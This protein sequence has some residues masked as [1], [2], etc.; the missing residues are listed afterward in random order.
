[1]DATTQIITTVAGYGGTFTGDNV[2]ATSTELNSPLGVTLDAQGNLYIADSGN[3]RVRR[4]DATTQIIT[5]V[6]GDGTQ[7]YSGDGKAA[8]DAELFIPQGLALDAAGNL[9]IADRDNC[10][11]YTSRCV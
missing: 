9:Y 5:T 2:P 10:L 1:M 3:Y 8:I 7:G 6:A 4:V 11:L